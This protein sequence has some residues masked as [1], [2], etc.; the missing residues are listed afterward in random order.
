MTKLLFICSANRLRSH[1]AE[2]LFSTYEGIEVIGAGTDRNAVTPVSGDLIEWADIILV[3]E[4]AHRNKLLKKFKSQ[5]KMKRLF[6]LGIPDTY[7]YM[8][9]ELIAL[10]KSKVAMI[11]PQ[12]RRG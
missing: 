8:Q 11:V 12:T 6:V 1:T 9:S 5:L 4:K 3:M 7:E 10:L 2:T